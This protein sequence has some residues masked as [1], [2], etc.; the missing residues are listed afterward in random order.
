MRVKYKIF[1]NL[2][3]GTFFLAIICIT[4]GAVNLFTA[5]ASEK[6]TRLIPKTNAEYVDGLT[7]PIATATD[8][9]NFFIIKFVN[10]SFFA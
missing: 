9:S 5:N 10:Y 6:S 8:G 3:L 2:I 1:K 7:S 4:L